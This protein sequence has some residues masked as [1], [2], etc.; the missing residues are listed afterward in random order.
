MF[1][2]L[3]PEAIPSLSCA[4]HE[5]TGYSCFTC[6]LTRS[7]LA[8]AH[9]H[10]S[11]SIGHHLMGPVAFLGMFLA[12]INLGTE[13]LIGRKWNPG[14]HAGFWRGALAFF[15]LL[16]ITYGGIRLALELAG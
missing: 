11:A 7:L 10:F 12:M 14:A 16:W 1:A 13:A 9:G 3:T 8:I 2:L 6:G 5:F 15:I 4:F